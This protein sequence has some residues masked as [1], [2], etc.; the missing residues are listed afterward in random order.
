MDK[1]DIYIVNP[2]RSIP[3]GLKLPFPRH[4]ISRRGKVLVGL[5]LE[6]ARE[7]VRS[8]RGCG[9]N[10]Y[11]VSVRYREPL[12]S[13][14]QAQRIADVWHRGLIESGR[15]LAELSDGM[16]D[17]LWWTFCADDLDALDAGLIPG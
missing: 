13:I 15:R 14:E 2:A 16:D 8:V 5:P 10:A 6:S 3:L 11:L 12:V 1:Y 17:V 9:A 7:A 4:A